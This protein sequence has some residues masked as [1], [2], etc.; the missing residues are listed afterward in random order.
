MSVVKCQCGASVRVPESAGASFRCP[1]CRAALST[2]VAQS[3]AQAVGVVANTISYPSAMSGA[4]TGA[5][6]PICQSAIGANEA[7]LDCPSC[8]QPHHRECWD[9]VGGCSIYGCDA[10]PAVTK[11]QDSSTPLS[12]WGDAKSCPMCGERIK[13]IALKCRYCGAAFDTVDPLSAF[14]IKDRLQRDKSSRSVRT[15]IIALF[16]FSVIG[17][18]APLMLLISCIWV[19]LNKETIRK[20]GPVYLVLGYA[21]IGLSAVYSVLMLI[22][23]ISGS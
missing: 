3:H 21:S 12:A 17:L 11:P 9:E 13:S 5:M 8:Q 19:L 4:S 22:F 1:R 15:S 18:L 14:D 10:A 6:C 20:A 23:A 16:I 2:S 7:Q